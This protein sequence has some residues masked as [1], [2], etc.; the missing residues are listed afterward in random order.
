MTKLRAILT[1]T[2]ASALLSL[3]T[4]NLRADDAATPSAPAATSAASAPASATTPEKLKTLPPGNHRLLEN[5][6]KHF[7][8]TYDQELEI[9]P[10]LHDEE[11]VSKP[12]LGFAAFTPAEQKAMLLTIKLAARRQIRPLLTPDQQAKL[13][14]EIAGMTKSGTD[15]LRASTMTAPGDDGSASAKKGSGKSKK[16]VASTEESITKAI[17]AYAAL[18]DAEKQTMIA[19]VKEASQRP[20]PVADQPTAKPAS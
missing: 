15:T 11:S 10:L 18:T 19:K 16:V 7:G 6:T 20:A 2:A 13:D 4:P 9:E 8:L 5:M 14:Q 17:L 3:A 12:I 1:L